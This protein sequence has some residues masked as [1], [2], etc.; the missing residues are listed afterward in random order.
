MIDL[1]VAGIARMTGSVRAGEYVGTIEEVTT[2]NARGGDKTWRI[3]WKLDGITAPRR[4]STP[5]GSDDG[6]R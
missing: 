3:H 5:P 6:G 2:S 4:P 1:T